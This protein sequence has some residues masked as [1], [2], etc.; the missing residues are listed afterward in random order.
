MSE[1]LVLRDGNSSVGHRIEEF[2]PSSS[3]LSTYEALREELDK[4]LERL[5]EFRSLE[6][7]EIFLILSS[8]TARATEIKIQLSR[9]DTSKS[10]GFRNKEIEPFLVECDRQFKYYSRMQ[11]TRELDFKISGGAT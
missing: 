11:T 2:K 7:D 10:A 1:D 5:Q 4:Y 3:N 8:L 6:L 9:T